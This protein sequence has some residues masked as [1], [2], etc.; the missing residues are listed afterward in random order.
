MNCGLRIA[1]CGFILEC[2]MRNADLIVDLIADW[3]PRSA[4]RTP[5]LIRTPHSAIRN[6]EG[7]P[8]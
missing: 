5:Q 1:D 3:N 2:G 7:G 8:R 6:D 4:L